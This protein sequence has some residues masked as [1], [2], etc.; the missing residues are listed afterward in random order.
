[1]LVDAVPHSGKN[2]PMA[3][4][5]SLA[6]GD[7]I[8]GYRLDEL[9]GRGGMGV[10]FR[11]THIALERRV[12]VKLIAPE[13]AA[14]E[15]FRQR[16]QRES[17]VA[18]SIDHPHVI[19]IFDAGDEDG[20]LY[21]AM[22]YVE[23]TDLGA[24]LAREGAL[25]PERAVDVIA[26]VADA[27]DA[28]HE[29]GLVHRDVKPANVLLE[30]RASGYHSYL[31]D[32]G[33]VK[34]VGAA[35]GAL[36]RTGQWL[37]TPDYAAPE[38][39][40]GAD[41]DARTDVYA[42]GCMLYH[43]ITGQPP[44]K[45][46]TDVAK[47]FAHLSQPPP[48]LLE[49][50]PDAPALLD[51]VIRRAMAKDPAE[52]QG[53]ASEL[54]SSAR[55]AIEGIPP[56]TDTQPVQPTTVAPVAETELSPTSLAR[57]PRQPAEPAEP[58]SVRR[59]PLWPVAAVAIVLV[60]VGV[61]VLL[62]SGGGDEED[63]TGGSGSATIPAGNL[64]SNPSFESDTSGWGVFNSELARE[65]ASDAPDGRHVVRV[66][67]VGSPDEYT[68]DDE[69]ETVGSSREGQVYTA[70]AWVKATEET[71]GTTICISLRE[72]VEDGGD[73]PFSAASVE[74]S[75]DEY[76]RVEVSHRATASGKTIGVHVFPALSG[77]EQGGSFLTD[78]I[79]ITESGDAGGGQPTSC[80]A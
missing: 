54:A 28:A 16:F 27:L 53:S 20:Q 58:P 55:Q 56:A 72:G 65:R 38:Q 52:R 12:A 64:T 34:T 36:T 29:R 46:D 79:A 31:T 7:V 40:N 48:S 24:L 22:R 14:D 39:I 35:S 77:V 11:A 50:K 74:A 43:A 3:D 66:S 78:A 5:I 68:I 61:V 45:G 62:A 59:R 10:V 75:A 19:P 41:V 32:F 18:A 9:A 25:E 23:G 76:R 33:L 67:L 1:L 30:R 13:L 49:A 2:G 69:P 17:R 37:G 70:S 60:A 8:A 63:P 51:G 26:Q 6:A 71:D 44:F 80:D 47:M 15:M 73:A 21:V 4:R 57:P 42:L